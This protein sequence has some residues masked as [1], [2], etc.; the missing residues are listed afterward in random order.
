M[1]DRVNTGLL[2][3]RLGVGIVFILHGWPKISGGPVQWEKIGGSAGDI[4]IHFFP[5][6]WGFMAAIAEFGGGILLI[7]GVLFRPACILILITMIVAMA[8]HVAQTQDYL[9]PLLA[10]VVFIGLIFTGPG[11]YRMTMKF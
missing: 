10:A 7:L 5:V 9:H 11:K 1:K 8:Q 3:L 4:G 6:F 2:L